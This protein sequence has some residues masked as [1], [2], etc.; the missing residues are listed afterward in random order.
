MPAQRRA[1][2]A[3]N[4]DEQGQYLTDLNRCHGVHAHEVSRQPRNRAIA[5]RDHQS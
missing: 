3:A 5:D 4:A 1:D 2:A